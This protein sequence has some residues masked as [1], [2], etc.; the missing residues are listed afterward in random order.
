MDKPE[1]M[2]LRSSVVTIVIG[3]IRDP[4]P[5]VRAPARIESYTQDACV[6]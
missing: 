1:V 6:D 4:C 2:S 3:A 5:L